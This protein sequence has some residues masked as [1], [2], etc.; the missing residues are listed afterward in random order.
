MMI[1]V[2]GSD[3]Q[4]GYELLRA[5]APYGRVTG[6]TRADGDLSNAATV[7]ALLDKYQPRCI[8]N[9][10]AYTAVDQAESDPTAAEALNSRLPSQLAA[11][12]KANDASLIHYST[13]YVYDGSGSRPWK[14]DDPVGPLSVYGKTKL[15]GDQAIIDADI[16]AVIFRT[17]WVYGARG[18]NFMLT[19]LKLA[20]ERDELN[21]VADQWGTPTP[22]WL[23]AQV[24]S[25]AVR[26]NLREK[27]SFK[28]LYHLTCRGDTNWCDFARTI[29]T[30]ARALGVALK[31]SLERVKPIP[32]M[33]YPAPAPRPLNSRLDVARL[34][35]AL[36]LELPHWEEALQL[37]VR[38]WTEYGRRS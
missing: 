25:V 34:E 3:G 5:L 12:A 32:T 26:E 2:T 36:G 27:G 23:I 35:Q 4:V 33:E 24:T 17:S 21:V 29:M 1:L 10:A 37:T 9:A 15:A 6:L 11:W 38:D 31:I 20:Q 28:G 19:M 14:E 8:V 16:G 7:G 22:A 30:D 13:D 18:R